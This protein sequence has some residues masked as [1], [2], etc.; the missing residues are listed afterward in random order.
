MKSRLRPRPLVLRYGVAVLA[1]A[2]ALGLSL[3]L[4]PVIEPTLF[5]FFF[6][7]LFVSTYRGGFGPGLVVIVAGA[8]G[9]N[10]FLMSNGPGF[11][12]EPV[13]LV[14]TGFFVAVASVA[15]WLSER[16]LRASER[17]RQAEDALIARQRE[18]RMAMSGLLEKTREL[19]HFAYVASHDLKEPIRKIASYSELLTTRYSDVLDGMALR[20]LAY[21]GEG[22]LRMKQLIEDL[23]TYASTTKNEETW[24][25]V[26]LGETAR[27][28]VT[29][30]ETAIE[31][32]GAVVTVEALPV[33]R[34][35]PTQLRQLLQNLIANA[36]K[37][38]SAAPPTV[39]LFSRVDGQNVM[40][41]VQDNGIGIASAYH[42]SIFEM[43]QRLH[44][45]Q[46]YEGTGIGLAV[47][48]RIVQ[49]HGGRLWVES[50]EGAGATFWFVLP[51]LAEN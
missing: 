44:S 1:S 34:G 43:F 5:I 11:N 41:G 40:V 6:A 20:Y 15:A 47:C 9:G 37:F 28:A 35:N 50:S 42:A 45:K 51:T 29:D 3:A 18:L 14:R 24:E 16:Q 30:L 46:L 23:L 26:D 33:V 4:R 36:I 8:L 21:I 17:A 27:L 25:K 49:H 48:K 39:R 10:Y 12:L 38:K 31:Q 7:A 13:A 2:A 22:A 32:Q 19:E